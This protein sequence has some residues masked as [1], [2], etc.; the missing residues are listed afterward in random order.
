MTKYRYGH[1]SSV[2]GGWY[3]IERKNFFG[4]WEWETFRSRESMMKVVQKL[5]S[6]PTNIVIKMN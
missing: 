1:K 4:W 6:I 5:E 3:S 2:M